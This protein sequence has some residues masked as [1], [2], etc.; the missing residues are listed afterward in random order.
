MIRKALGVAVILCIPGVAVGDEGL[1]RPRQMP[2][3]KEL[4]PTSEAAIDWGGMAD[5]K[6]SPMSAML[7]FGGC[8][9]AF[10]SADGLIVTNYHCAT[11]SV[12]F[13][14]SP[15][16]NLLQDGFVARSQADELPAVPTLRVQLMLAAEDVTLRMLEGLGGVEGEARFDAIDRRRKAIVRECETSSG[17][18]CQVAGF[19][20][21]L[22][23]SL[24]RTLE[25]RDVRLVYAPPE[26]V[27]RY[28]GD[29]DNFEW[30]RQTGDFALF[31]AYAGPDG[32]PADPSPGNRRYQPRSFLKIA[33]D[34]LKEGEFVMVVGFPGSTNRYRPAAEVE[35][36]FRSYYPRRIRINERSLEVLREA[37]KGHKDLALRYAG[38]DAELNN[39]LKYAQGMVERFSRSGL[40]ARTQ[41][42]DRR[43]QAWIEADPQRKAAYGSALETLVAALRKQWESQERD[44]WFQAATR[45][46]LLGTAR[47]L[48]RLALEKQ[49]PDTERTSGY[50]ERDWGGIRQGLERMERGFA[51]EV[52]AAVWKAFLLDYHREARANERRPDL[53]AWFGLKAGQDATVKVTRALEDMYRRTRL[54]DRAHRL[55]LMTASAAELESSSDPFM[56]LAVRLSAAERAREK[57]GQDM[58]GTIQAA[59]LVYMEAL[60]RFLEQHGEHVYPD[61]NGTLRVS[62][63]TVKGYTKEDGVVFPPFSTAED[64]VQKNTGEKP[65]DTPPE[66]LRLLRAKGFGAY[67]DPA[68]GTL[69]VNFLATVDVTGGSSGS[70]TLNSRGELVGLL[71]D[72]NQ[73][74]IISAWN[75]SVKLSRSIHVDIRYMLW[76]LRDVERAGALLAE[77]G[78]SPVAPTD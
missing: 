45:S 71:F 78:A 61:A 63:G 22:E 11:S 57:R 26:G 62:W 40:L 23:Y 56:K 17:D 36:T 9:G 1:W 15:E 72:I 68:L 38:S 41:E 69:P 77:L 13:N 31:R 2:E 52:D 27:G 8:S 44:S 18:R 3:V 48:Y 59:R 70:P 60:V 64:L 4:L 34:G 6:A 25:L 21:G 24:I 53:D 29:V 32:R 51:P 28:G 66:T 50:Q 43:L 54:V 42:R 30:P 20:G 46:T 75:Y 76:L 58:G 14:S 39:T 16:H 49:K 74:G 47:R 55:S 37:T 33:R 73:E 12:Q 35:Q 67:R 7:K 5:L 19:H 65:F 10:V